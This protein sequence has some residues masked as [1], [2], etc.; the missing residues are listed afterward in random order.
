MAAAGPAGPGPSMQGFW[1]ALPSAVYMH[2]DGSPGVNHAP[3]GEERIILGSAGDIQYW[4]NLPIFGSILLERDAYRRLW[5]IVSDRWTKGLDPLILGSSG[6]GKTLFLYYVMWKLRVQNPDVEIVV[7]ISTGT[8]RYFSRAAEGT[9]QIQEGIA[10]HR[11]F[12][13]QLSNPNTYCRT[14]TPGTRWSSSTYTS[15]DSTKRKEAVP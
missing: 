1:A 5:E 9:E 3:K 13:T 7:E 14:A 11:D 4:F 15:G 6:I 2:P 8:R 12:V 10:A